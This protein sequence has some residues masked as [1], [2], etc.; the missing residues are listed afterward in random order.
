VQI[1]GLNQYVLFA[2]I[3]QFR[4]VSWFYGVQQTCSFEND[5]DKTMVH[6]E[7]RNLFDKFWFGTY[8]V[9]KRSFLYRRFSK[10]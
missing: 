4:E 8:L 10:L 7:F 9:S 6:L 2:E 1:D 5:I 3:L